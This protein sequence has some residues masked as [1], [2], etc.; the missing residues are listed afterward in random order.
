MGNNSMGYENLIV[1][2][3]ASGMLLF[4]SKKL[5]IYSD[6][7]AVQSLNMKRQN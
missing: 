7:W 5:P 6:P 2:V 1:V 4:G 3:L